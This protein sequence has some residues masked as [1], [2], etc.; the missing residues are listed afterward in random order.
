VWATRRERYPSLCR[1][2]LHIPSRP[3]E[4]L[5][6]GGFAHPKKPKNLLCPAS[7]T[8]CAHEAQPL[9]ASIVE[10]DG[11]RADISRWRAQNASDG[12]IRP[13]NFRHRSRLLF[14]LAPEG[15]SRDTNPSQLSRLAKAHSE[16]PHAPRLRNPLI[17]LRLLWTRQAA[18]RTHV[19]SS[20]LPLV[21]S[22]SAQLR[23]PASLLRHG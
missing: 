21:R 3:L 5:Q 19:N 20:P 4:F 17:D 22:N 2:R 8:C 9:R 23:R 6:R 18:L 11:H 1:E 15:C 16:S 13:G 14:V 7:K 12:D 10:S